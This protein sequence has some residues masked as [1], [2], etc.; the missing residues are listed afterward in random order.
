MYVYMYCR[1]QIILLFT[2][3]LSLCISHDSKMYSANSGEVCDVAC[4][5]EVLCQMMNAGRRD[6]GPQH[7]PCIN[8]K[9]VIGNITSSCDKI[10]YTEY[11][12]SRIHC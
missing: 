11:H 3:L 5:C 1:P 7:D 2:L 8:L 12:R 4:E 6:P 9:P 10:D